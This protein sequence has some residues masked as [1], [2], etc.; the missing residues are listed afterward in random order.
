M[1]ESEICTLA[2]IVCC[3]IVVECLTNLFICTNARNYINA[4][5]KKNISCELNI[6]E[7]DSRHKA[8]KDQTQTVTLYWILLV[9]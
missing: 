9:V 4:M 7:V 8:G 1:S 5:Y 3:V 6:L 2:H